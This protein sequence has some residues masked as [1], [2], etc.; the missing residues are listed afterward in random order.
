MKTRLAAG[1]FSMFS[2]SIDVPFMS[3]SSSGLFVSRRIASLSW[4]R[5][6]GMQLFSPISTRFASFSTT[7][8]SSTTRT[9][10]S[11]SSPTAPSH[12]SASS[13][14]STSPFVAPSSTPVTSGHISYRSPTEIRK[15]YQYCADKVRS[16][17]YEGFLCATY[18]PEKSRHAVYAL[19]AWNLE[20]A[21]VRDDT[22]NENTSTIRFDWWR[23][24]INNA[25][26]G[27]PPEH[28]LAVAIA[29]AAQEFKFTRTWFTKIISARERDVRVI[30]P[31]AI[32]DL[33][34]YSEETAS[35][36]LYL[37]LEACGLR[38]HESEHAASH[39]GKAIGISTLLRATPYH[40]RA[41]H[42]Y[43]PSS[44]TTKHNLVPESLF[45]GGPDLYSPVM[46][47]VVFEIACTAKSHVDIALTM[48]DRLPL[49]A[50]R[51]LMPLIPARD[52]LNRLEK[53]EF[54]VFS[55]AL[56]H[57][58]LSLQFRLARN[59]FSKSF[60]K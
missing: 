6:R 11:E 41:R 42:C 12:P 60:K 40:L 16:G 58:P 54:D 31:R 10:T 57:T 49:P 19:R 52:F 1:L 44:L 3:S 4:L 47:D 14:I 24:C 38:N 18:L 29:D 48:H 5:P 59:Y 32:S 45:R 27:S 8:K 53:H 37:T 26:K 28:P 50:R 34:S 13:S 23:A 46:R 9:T 36:L 51:A 17:D 21:S 25:L 33:E 55:E 30:Q 56:S 15:A 7:A 20:V 35:S 2:A 39:I 43:I 22:T